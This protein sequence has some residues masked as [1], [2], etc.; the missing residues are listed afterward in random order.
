MG[1]DNM[2]LYDGSDKLSAVSKSEIALESEFATAPDDKKASN[3]L[4][5]N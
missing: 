2:E 4:T 3:A 1:D 5:G